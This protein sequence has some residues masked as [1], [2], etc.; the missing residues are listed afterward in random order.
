M[1]SD[2]RKTHLYV[3]LLLT[4]AI[5]ILI[6][7]TAKNLNFNSS[8]DRQSYEYQNL[9]TK[10]LKSVENDLIKLNLYKNSLD[11]ILKTPLKQPSIAIYS[12]VSEGHKK[13]VLGQLS[14]VGVYNF[15]I[16]E[17]PIGIEL[18]DAI[19]EVTITKLKF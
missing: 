1:T 14:T 13:E 17:I 5:A 8:P 3:W 18:Y 7:F 4:I 19:K 2:L 6:F 11:V 12:I 16:N 9:A 10:P 15:T